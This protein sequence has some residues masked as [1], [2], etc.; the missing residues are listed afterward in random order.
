MKIVIV[1]DI[2][3]NSDALSHVSEDYDELWVLGDLVNYGPQP[4]EV[5]SFI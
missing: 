4:S 1:S 5:I 3:G 2:H